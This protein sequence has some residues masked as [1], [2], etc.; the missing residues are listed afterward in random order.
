MSTAP[1]ISIGDP[2]ARVDGVA[3]VTGSARYAAEFRITGLTYASVVLSTVASGRIV[4]IDRTAAEH[5][6]GV[7]AVITP[8][9][10]M[11]L[12]GPERRLTILQDDEVFYQNQP[13]AVI[14]AETLEQARFAA[15]R[16]MFVTK[17]RPRSWTSRLASQ[18]RIPPNTTKS[19]VIRAGE[20]W[21]PG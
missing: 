16:V 21:M 5:L 17:P 6:P 14:V 18:A 2:L 3:K 8:E 12:A 9:N 7:I 10:A 11:R 13:V 15:S 20:M 1:P 4:T 19:P